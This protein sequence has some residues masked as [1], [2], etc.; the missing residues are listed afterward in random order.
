MATMTRVR[1][2]YCAVQLDPRVQG[3]VDIL[4]ST[5]YDASRATQ[6]RSRPKLPT[7]SAGFYD[8]LF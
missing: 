3:Y 2:P 1:E 4:G 8:E 5:A 6:F 7:E